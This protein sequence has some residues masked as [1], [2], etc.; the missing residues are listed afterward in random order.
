VQ[1]V[2][3]RADWY[4][5]LT[6][7]DRMR[8]A[9]GRLPENVLVVEYAPQLDLLRQARVLICHGGLGT[10][11]EAILCGVPAIVFPQA[12]DQWGNAARVAH[13]RLGLQGASQSSAEEVGKMIDIAL[14]EGGIRDSVRHMQAVFE[15]LQADSAAARVIEDWIGA[16]S[17][18]AVNLQAPKSLTAKESRS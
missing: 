13:H 7:E 16:D 12:F 4:L 10:L 15:Q 2:R 3:G 6:A 1:A 18:R 14:T 8:D 17:P 9:L 11:K 5:V